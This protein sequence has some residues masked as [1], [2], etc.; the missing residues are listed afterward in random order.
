M[1]KNWDN[2]DSDNTSPSLTAISST[3]CQLRPSSHPA[4][5]RTLPENWLHLTPHPTLPPAL[6]TNIRFYYSFDMYHQPTP[7]TDFSI[8]N[9]SI[10]TGN[11]ISSSWS[12]RS[13]VSLD[14]YWD[15]LRIILKIWFIFISG[16]IR[17]GLRTS[18]SEVDNKKSLWRSLS[19]C[20]LM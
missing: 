19:W 8:H 2:V 13:Y 1:E 3:N 10:L 11:K 14:I 20:N 16:N 18:S 17:G 6:N 7:G 15:L 5:I 4:V 9:L 12:W